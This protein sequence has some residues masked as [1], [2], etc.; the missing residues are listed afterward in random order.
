MVAKSAL[1]AFI[2]GNKLCSG[3]FTTFVTNIYRDGHL[4][5]YD[6]TQN[7]GTVSDLHCRGGETF[8]IDLATQLKFVTKTLQC[9]Q[10]GIF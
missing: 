8:V 2:K 1:I 10:L 5:T 6:G 7:N 3:M 9:T 4:G